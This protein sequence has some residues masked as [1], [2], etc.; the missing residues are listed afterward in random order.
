MQVPRPR[1]FVVVCTLWQAGAGF[2]C[3]RGCHCLYLRAPRCTNDT[4][5]S[6]SSRKS[7]RL[8]LAKAAMSSLSPVT[9]A[10][11]VSVDGYGI[12]ISWSWPRPVAAS[13]SWRVW[14][15]SVTIRQ[16]GVPGGRY[17]G[18]IPYQGTTP[19][20]PRSLLP[21]AVTGLP[22]VLNKAQYLNKA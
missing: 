5:L 19:Q 11:R 4:S 1:Q 16:A 8:S 10:A 13:S 18:T 22:Q 2:L 21:A 12:I 14:P 15:T 3:R 7:G 6:S 17:L 20:N 9:V